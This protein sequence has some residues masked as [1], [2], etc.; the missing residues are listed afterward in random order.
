[1]ANNVSIRLGVEGQADVKRAFDDAGRA[2]QD[3]FRGVA[4]ALDAAGAA[5]D[6]QIAKFRTLAQAGRDAAAKEQ[7][8]ANVNSIL[9]VRPVP[10]G[11]ARDSA[12]VFE[13]QAHASEEAARRAEALG[14]EMETLRSRFDPLGAAAARYQQ[15]L[16]DVARAED[17]GAISS[18]AAATVRLKELRSYDDAT[19]KI[20]N[21]AA[22][23]KAAAQV[24]VNRQ[25]VVPDRG[26]DIAAYGTEMDRLR[27]KYSPLF[28]VQREY[29]AQ[30]TEIR[31]AVKTGALTQVEG[32]SAL[33]R[34]KDTFAKQVTDLRAK[35]GAGLTGSQAQNLGYQVSDV[36]SS[37]GSGSSVT[38]V[39]FQQV[40]QI[41]QIFSGPGGASV[42]GAVTQATEAVSGFVSRIGVMGGVLGGA[43]AVLLSGVAAWAA[44]RSGQ[45]EVARSVSGIGRASGATVA[46][47]NAIAEA[48]SGAAGISRSAAREMQSQYAATGQIGTSMYGKLLGSARDYAASTRQSLPDANKALAEAFADPVQGAETLNKQLGFLDDATLQLITRLDAQGNRL[49]AQ[50]VLFEAYSTS[51]AKATER[52]GFFARG[53]A[54]FSKNSSNEIDAVGS[55]IERG[56]GGG[57]A[58][59]RMTALQGQLDFRTRNKGKVGG[60]L[61]SALDGLLGFDEESIR[62]EMAGV[63]KEIDEGLT[64][65]DKAQ[66]AQKSLQIGSLIRSMLPEQQDLQKTQN[67]VIKLRE[68]ISQ[69]VKFGL[70]ARALA[71]LEGAFERIQRI[72][73]ATSEDIEKYGSAAQAAAVRAA[74]FGNRTV[75]FTGLGRAGAEAQE[76]FNKK[77]RDGGLN[78]NERSVDQINADFAERSLRTDGRDQNALELER[79]ERVKAAAEVEALRRERDLNVNTA[80]KTT[81]LS[82]SNLGGAFAKMGAELRT[83]FLEVAAKPEN[84][85]I[86]VGVAAAIA[87]IES[88]GKLDIGFSKQRG[89]DG[90]ASSSFGLGQI[91]TDTAN[92]AVKRGFLP[93]DFDR[94]N[95]DTM[96]EGL[97]GVLRMKIKD[98]GGNLDQGIVNYRGSTKPGVGQDYLLQ[99][100]RGAGEMGDLSQVGLARDLDESKRAAK[101]AADQV[102]NLSDNY[103]KNGL[104]AEVNERA[105]KLLNDAQV[106]GKDRVDGYTD[107]I[108]RNAQATILAER[109]QTSVRVFR[110]LAFDQEQI[111]RTTGEQAVYAA[112]RS[113]F[114]DTSAGNVDAQAFMQTARLNDNLR[115]TKALATDAFSSMLSDLRQGVSLSTSLSNI[116]GRLADKMFSKASDYIFSSLFAG[117]DKSGGGGLAMIA[118]LFGGKAAGY[119]PGYA[120]G[121][122]PFLSREG[123]VNG[124]GT[125]TSDSMLVRI[126]D[127]EAIIR[128]AS[129]Q[130]YGSE[131]IRSINEGTFGATSNENVPGYA[132]GRTPFTVP[133]AVA[134]ASANSPNITLNV[135]NQSS[136]AKVETRE[137]ADGRGGRKQEAVIVDAFVQGAS[138]R[139]GQ[140]AMSRPQIGST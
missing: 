67:I 117:A 4:T 85:M 123:V 38:Q 31:N 99:V 45:D 35:N 137:V 76:V 92:D 72:A 28:A 19:S 118:S 116:T 64:K 55:F 89:E 77:I 66:A 2:G 127:K 13:M 86:P 91:N 101:L 115:E 8:Q 36:V 70:D 135:I 52:Q 9:G 126:S 65:I 54:E 136:N 119:V 120:T 97:F 51:V 6:R 108:K 88:S 110:D 68:Y 20:Q 106:Q 125:P 109:A 46:Q 111:G 3:A 21:M 44:Y 43:T 107:A 32:S 94:T 39:A 83:K 27:A 58:E 114:G 105:A 113:R 100:K 96:V 79:R 102:K 87:R 5:S 15:A 93:K 81:T 22:A 62:K 61:G 40:P 90:R 104:Q 23:Q 134:V 50:R 49:G 82:E 124:P 122:V 138:S 57:T 7:A 47:I 128:A 121:K 69:P 73:R 24:A 56:L 18:E 26:A 131:F 42:K 75:G 80:A 11:A 74:E 71:E 30:L 29:V 132:A 17:I 37:L 130:R 25:T 41:A 12:G 84:G 140:R 78:P 129:V 63:Q 60:L 34:T 103:G 133:S 59:E 98:A 139:Q 16:A 95:V 112:A 48:Q 33:Q 1:M 10:T 14:R 53:W